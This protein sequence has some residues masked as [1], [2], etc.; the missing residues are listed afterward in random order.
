[1]DGT[2]LYC[3]RGAVCAENTEASITAAVENMCRELFSRHG[4]RDAG[5]IVSVQ[6]TITPDLDALNPAT[7]FRRADSGVAPEGIPLFCAQEP[8]ARNML[9]K[10]I[11][12]MVTVYLPCGTKLEPVY[13]NGA[14]ALRPD[15]RLSKEP[16]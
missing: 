15:L 2:R 6:F 3:L 10:V 7:A 16:R 8:A 11:R 12:V 13:L 9:A 1:M 4:V 5:Q 14:E